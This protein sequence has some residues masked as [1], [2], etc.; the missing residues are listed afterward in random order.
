MSKN[1]PRVS[2]W[3]R[4]T[5]QLSLMNLVLIVVFG[6]Y[7]GNSISNF[8]STIE[9]CNKISD[10]YLS[11]MVLRGDM[12]K[13]YE[14]IQR[15]IYAYLATNDVEERAHLLENIDKRYNQLIEDIEQ[16]QSYLEGNHDVDIADMKAGLEAYT[17]NAKNALMSSQGK[18]TEAVIEEIDALE[19]EDEKFDSNL[20]LANAFFEQ[21]IITLRQEQQDMYDRTIRTSILGAVAIIVVVGINQVL[22]QFNIIRPIKKSS[23]ELHQM[24]EKI[25]ENKGDLNARIS[26]RTRSELSILVGGM[27]DFLETL[28]NIINKVSDGTKALAQSNDQIVTMVK[29]ANT[30]I[31]ESSAALE[32]LAANME[33]ISSTSDSIQNTIGGVKAQVDVLW[34]EANQGSEKAVKV[35]DDAQAM[36]KHIVEVKSLTV[37]KVGEM[38]ELLNRS[39]QN[40]E[41]VTKIDTLSETIMN[42]A[43]ETTLLSLNASIEAARAGEA[44]RGFAVVANQINSLSDNSQK[45]AKDIQHINQEVVN[46]VQELAANTSE[47]LEY[48]NNN[49]LKDYDQFVEAMDEYVNNMEDFYAILQN[50]SNSSKGLN[51]SMGNIINSVEF[52]TSAMGEGSTAMDVSAENATSLV[53]KMNEVQSAVNVCREVSDMLGQEIKHFSAAGEKA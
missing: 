23:G 44:G 32:E 14:K 41:K 24:I 36:K 18:S 19:A 40:C 26:T 51:D 16:L 29:T 13:D 21:S 3:S 52:I 34:E 1:I 39:I 49:I 25:D 6:I 35:S 38:T 27:N 22:F 42:I 30:N 10:T 11:A 47:V 45:T 33:N 5:T 2:F 8:R 37:N 17:E 53:D 48:I 7:F 4:I 43:N 46:T 50:F 9:K 20:E 15:Y 12:K 28:Q 31:T